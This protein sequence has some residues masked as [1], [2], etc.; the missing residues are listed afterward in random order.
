MDDIEASLLE[1][2]LE[3]ERAIQNENANPNIPPPEENNNKNS[4]NKDAPA[5]PKKKSKLKKVSDTEESPKK[6]KKKKKK[7]ESD[8]EESPKK[9]QKK[10]HKEESEQEE[11]VSEGSAME[12]NDATSGGD[13][14]EPSGESI[15][16]SV[17]HDSESEG[18][19]ERR[20]KEQDY[21]ERKKQ[22]KLAEKEAARRL[23]KSFI[24]DIA[25]ES[26]SDAE[27]YV[28]GL[29]KRDNEEEDGDNAYELDSDY[30]DNEDE[31]TMET[32]AEESELEVNS[33]M[34]KKKSKKRKLPS[35]DEED[36]GEEEEKDEEA[37]LKVLKLMG[38]KEENGIKGSTQPKKAPFHHYAD[39]AE[40]NRAVKAQVIK[41][42][43]PPPA[44]P[45]LK[46][47]G[48]SPKK[49]T[50]SPSKSKTMSSPKSTNKKKSD[51]LKSPTKKSTT[52]K[53]AESKITYQVGALFEIRTEL[54]RVSFRGEDSELQSNPTTGRAIM[55]PKEFHP[56]FWTTAELGK[57]DEASGEFLSQSPKRY[58]HFIVSKDRKP[59][60]I[61]PKWQAHEWANNGDFSMNE[62]VQ[63]A[64]QAI[65]HRNFETSA[66]G[67]TKRMYFEPE[68]FATI[69]SEAIERNGETVWCPKHIGDRDV[70]S[71]MEPSGQRVSTSEF[72]T[73][74]VASSS[75]KKKSDAAKTP[76]KLEAAFAKQKAQAA[77]K[78]PPSTQEAKASTSS[79]LDFDDFFN[80]APKP[81]KTN[82]QHANQETLFA[83]KTVN[84]FMK[85]SI[86][87]HW[88]NK[89]V[90]GPKSR[91]FWE[92]IERKWSQALDPSAS[93]REKM[94]NVS[95]IFKPKEGQP[96]NLVQMLFVCAPF[97]SPAAAELVRSKME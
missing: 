12:D 16:G 21:L 6:K 52:K 28:N 46:A 86:E 17:A 97:L 49:S 39:I 65:V 7:S 18:E 85:E 1:D 79:S 32:G 96:M 60:K 15:E 40:H 33:K 10:K 22:K 72:A 43:P 14:E 30:M 93:L 2:D 23:A 57:M 74:K 50:K 9:K 63:Y 89:L 48:G 87:L 81:V 71:M 78:S 3:A 38:G 84:D 34:K 27:E 95:D 67:T 77:A 8:T 35:S 75:D 73:K 92:D 66:D 26:G 88:K 31:V 45:A 56:K 4:N 91:A 20:K 47:M 53:S 29:K 64:S 5:S 41:K 36:E 42:E 44:S 70:T 54:F 90:T 11:D 55:M 25:D 69:R 82:N 61:S 19:V 51:G 80:E 83:N 62:K 76:S 37:Q 94:S 58:Q 13:S 59:V 68:F 24:D